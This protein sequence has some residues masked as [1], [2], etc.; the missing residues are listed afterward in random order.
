MGHRHDFQLWLNAPL[1][2][3]E[4]LHKVPKFIDAKTDQMAADFARMDGS[5]THPF[6]ELSLTDTQEFAGT[7]QIDVAR[8]IV[9]PRKVTLH[10][11][12]YGTDQDFVWDFEADHNS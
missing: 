2:N 5:H 8:K 7:F 6:L 10:G 11:I 9:D 4:L 3:F 1:R 12:A